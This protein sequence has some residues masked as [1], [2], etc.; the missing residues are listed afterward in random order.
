MN[1]LSEKF[2]LHDKYQLEMKFTYPLDR[3]RKENTYHVDTYVFF[4]GSLVTPT[5]YP[6]ESFYADLQEYIRLKTPAVLLQVMTAG[7][8]SPLCKLE[9][10]MRNL[11]EHPDDPDASASYKDR[12]KMFCSIMKSAL[13]DE[14]S[15][16]ERSISSLQFRTLAENYLNHT[17]EILKQFR[18]LRLIVENPAVRETDLELFRLVDEFLSITANKYRYKF[19]NFLTVQPA[20]SWT[21]E[22]KK[23][24]VNVLRDEI[25]HRRKEQY[26]SIPTP[27]S[28]NENLIY[29]ES[30]LKKCMASVLFLKTTVRRDGVLVENLFFGIAAGIAMTFA[31]LVTRLKDLLKN[32][33]Q[34]K[35]RRYL[36]DFKTEIRSGLG[37]EVGVCKE[38]FSFVEE[39]NVDR[40]ILK[41][42][43]RN[44][45]TDFAETG[46]GESVILARKHVAISTAN[47]ANLFADFK[48]DGIVDIMRFNIRKF[49]WRMDNPERIVF[50]PDEKGDVVRLKGKRVYHMNII[51]RYGM[52]G[53]EDSYARYRIVL[54][55]NGIKRIDT[56]PIQTSV[57]GAV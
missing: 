57:N 49:L 55:R 10:S 27:D 37:R 4:P 17:G 6:K 16:L 3:N 8:N 9:T 48:V 2:K 11:F 15:F 42:R 31:T 53:R 56:F 32:Y 22:L 46:F 35:I 14:E 33:F 50:L 23:Q 40:N 12:L 34:T 18:H 38:G 44:H 52:E 54:S 45:L 51:I 36:Y 28:D 41:I 43:H 13:R 1:N 29:R 47:C 30:S 39:T 20:E 5:S 26:P 25:A 19:W 21:E 7:E 24:I